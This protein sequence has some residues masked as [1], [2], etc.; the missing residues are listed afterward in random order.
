MI[1]RPLTLDCWRETLYLLLGLATESM[2]F[3]VVVTGVSLALGLAILIV[4]LPIAVAVA[5]MGP[6]VLRDRPDS[7]RTCVRSAGAREIRAAHRRD[8][9]RRWVSVL[10]DL[11]IWRDMLWMLA[12]FP[13]TIVGFVVAVTAWSVALAL[14]AAPFYVWA[15]GAG[16]V[17]RHVVLVSILG[18]IA[19]IP[20]TVL[21]AWLVRGAAFLQAEMAELLLG[22]RKSEVLEQ[23]VQTLSETRAGA[24]DAAT[25]ELPRIERDLHD[26][27]QARLVALGDGARAWPS[28]G[29]TTIPRGPRARRRRPTARPR[30]RSSSCAS[31]SRDLSGS[32]GRPRARR[33]AR[34]RSLTACRS[35]SH[36]SLDVPSVRRA[37]ARSPRTSS[38]PRRSP[39]SASTATPSTHDDPDRAHGRP[40]RRARSRTTGTAAP[41][42]RS[43]AA[44]AACADRV[45]ALDGR[46]LVSSPTGGPD[47]R[48]GG[49][50]V[51]VVIA[52]DLALLRE[53]L[54]RLL[55]DNGFKVVAAVDR[56]RR[57]PRA[58]VTE[59]ARRRGR[60]RAASADLPRRGPARGARGARAA[61]RGSRC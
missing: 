42:A 57:V 34:A 61:S 47:D 58:V 26:G 20:A 54:V 15:T 46:L 3:T 52:E 1:R 33:G 38:S 6:L 21:A 5:F 56:R 18:P 9:P 31:S 8:G 45:A 49:D 23:R 24:V 2:A 43:G 44:C 12:G 7:R 25:A 27:A 14:L 28:S 4:G 40:G 30:Q 48:A 41:T 36:V 29:S 17:A 13:V 19:G 55:E 35:R 60:R 39:T 51:R 22:P 32:P 10:R 50:A 11:Q 37:R 59:Q 16:W 53:G